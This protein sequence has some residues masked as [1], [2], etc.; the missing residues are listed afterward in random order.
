MIPVKYLTV[1]LLILFFINILF[2]GNTGKIA[3]Q[4][5]DKSSGDPLIG[6]NVV[7]K[8]THLGAA[9][10]E[11]GF[12]FILQIPPGTYD[13]EFNYIGYH[14]LNVKQLR[15]KVDLTQTLNVELESDAVEGPTIEVIAD[16]LIVQKDVTSTRRTASR[17]DIEETPGFQSTND[18]FL[19]QGGSFVDQGAQ[20]ISLG[21]GIQL[22]VRDESLKDIHVRGGRG[23]EILY[24]VDGVPVT[25]PIY[26]GRD[27]LNLNV[28]DV[29]EME[30]LTGAFNAEYGQAQSGVVNITTRSGG[31]RYQGGI[32][33]KTAAV[34]LISDNHDF[35]YTS[36]YV[37]GPEPITRKLLPSIGLRFPG[38]LNFFLSGNATLSDTPYNN[39]RQRDD[40]SI[41][42]IQF[43]K[44]QDNMGN[45]NAKINWT[46][47]NRLSLILS[48]HGS[49]NSWSPYDWLWIDQ[50]NKMA[51]YSRKNQNLNFSVKHTLS[52]S[53]FYNL[54]FGYLKVDYQGSLNGLQPSDFWTFYKD[55]NE[56]DYETYIKNFSGA[57]DSLKTIAKVPQTDVYGFI[58]DQS[59]SS[60]WRDDLTNSLSFT[61]DITS[62]IH[63]DHLTKAGIDIRYNDLQY[64]DIQDGGYVL[65]KYGEHVFRNDPEFPKPIGPFPEFGLNRWVFQSFPTI[66]GMYLQ[67]KFEKEALIINAGVRFDWLLLGPSVMEDDFKQQWEAATGLEANWKAYKYKISP[68]FGIS[69]PIS[70][71]TVLFFSYGHF[72]Q[73]PE[74][75]YYYRDPYTGS[76]TGNPFLDYEQ[77]ILYE[78]GFTHQLSRDWAIDIKSYAKD[79]SQQV[80]TTE[81]RAELGLPVYLYDNKGYARARGLEF[82][83]IKRYS[84]FFSGKINYTVQWANGYS[85]SAFDDYIRSIND[86]PNPI[87]ERPLDWDI[88]NQ[89]I[90]QMAI[91][92]PE[93]RAP[94]LFGLSLGDN[95]SFSVL[96]R[97]AS[98]Q[99]YTPFT[100]DP[101]VAQVTENT[102]S[103]PF[104]TITDLKLIKT[105]RIFS[106]RLGIFA[107]LFNIFNHKNVQIRYGFNNYTGKPYVYGD[108]DPQLTTVGLSRLVSWYN[109]QTR[110][111]PRQFASFRQIRLGM[112]IDF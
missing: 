7:V 78:F 51:E 47:S 48:Y 67:D 27:V 106:T 24:M 50:S 77:T 11:D 98:G 15:V 102:V 97:F 90:F 54:N 30:L 40:L 13:I 112:K 14:N 37:G 62:Q 45:L 76:F 74:M 6:V 39:G 19:L 66:G 87:R 41:V 57:P 94:K 18:I 28:V 49:S 60:I 34:D 91:S 107:E 33:Y 56:Y 95:W 52:N 110:L 101:A 84:N 5:M 31:E 8:G 16:Q 92:A 111:D 85:S 26:G 46:L 55:G 80:Q 59:Y 96:S 38:K 64:V 82:E 25:H 2:A 100:L 104:T 12:Y 81:L 71:H 103:A 79:I 9:T 4:V 108:V 73:L 63:P 89:I 17:S 72:N 75:Q 29:Q 20:A 88:R 43:A 53:T 105:F 70:E 83:L 86:F 35:R 61:G 99:P 65:S 69:F 93:N 109:M 21:E 58:D 22:Q 32:E 10:D 44:L 68:R 3:G 23:G 1:N 42:G 36:F